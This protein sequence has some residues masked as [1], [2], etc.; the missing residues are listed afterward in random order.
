MLAPSPAARTAASRQAA[1]L[2]ASSPTLGAI[3]QQ[4]TVTPDVGD[5]AMPPPALVGP[6]GPAVPWS[7]GAVVPRCR[8]PRCGDPRC[9]GRSPGSHAAT[10]A[11]HLITVHCAGGYAPTM[12]RV[13]AARAGAHRARAEAA[14]K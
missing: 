10:R 2:A 12:H 13:D 4:A 8:D 3:W 1:R 11:A 14:A 5:D 6:C 7:R 9:R